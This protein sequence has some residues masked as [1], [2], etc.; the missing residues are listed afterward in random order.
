MRFWWNSN[1]TVIWIQ[2]YNRSFIVSCTQLEADTRVFLHEQDMSRQGIRNIK[3]RTFDA[4]VVVI[5]IV[6]I[7]RLNLKDLWVELRTWNKEVFYPVHLI[8]N[9]LESG[10]YKALLFL[11]AFTGWDQVSYFNMCKKKVA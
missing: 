3:I 2:R 10:K 11:H 4:D 8:Y 9:N 1:E 7:S 5:A 6:L